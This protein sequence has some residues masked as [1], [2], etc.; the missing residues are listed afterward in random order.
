M[1]SRSSAVDS[2][3]LSLPEVSRQTG[4]SMP[5][6]LRLRRE[7][8]EAIP[9][10]GSGSQRYFSPDVLPTLLQLY[11]AERATEGTRESTLFLSVPRR[12]I[13]SP[14]VHP[15]KRAQVKASKARKSKRS[16]RSDDL[17]LARRLIALENGQRALMKEI[18]LA[19]DHLK[20]PAHGY[21]RHVH[22]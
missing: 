20:K 7:N 10:T 5:T 13:A 15:D 16:H 14:R 18:Q 12:R 9:S 1:S 4:I 3:R 17:E 19:L 21:L 2:S 8:A 22:Q 6:I 11:Q